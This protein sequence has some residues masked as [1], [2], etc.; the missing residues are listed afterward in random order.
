[1]R[2]ISLRWHFQWHR[3]CQVRNSGC[4][5]LYEC[6]AFVVREQGSRAGMREFRYGAYG[7]V[8]Y[9]IRPLY[10]GY[11]RGSMVLPRGGLRLRLLMLFVN[12]SSRC[13]YPR[14][15]LVRS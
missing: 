12:S 6:N 2:D 10:S 7:P 13:G 3:Y 8:F 15:L 4:P 9:Q 14:L 5:L 1:M 11:Q